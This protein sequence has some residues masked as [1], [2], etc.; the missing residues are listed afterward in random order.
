MGWKSQQAWQVIRQS[1]NLKTKTQ[2]L[3]ARRRKGTMA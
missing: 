3:L 2:R 1:E